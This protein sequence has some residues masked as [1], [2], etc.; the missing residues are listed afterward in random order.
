MF[1][2]IVYDV[3]RRALR[4][5][6]VAESETGVLGQPWDARS[7]PCWLTP[8][9]IDLQVN[10]L[11]GQPFN[12]ETLTTEAVHR[13]TRRLWQEG[14]A[15]YCPTLIT[16][17]VD[18]LEH[19][20]RTIARAAQDEPEGRAIVG[21]HLEG[22][23]I[24]PETGPRGAHPAEH[25]CDPDRGLFERLQEA[26]QGLIT[27]V[28]LAPERPGA[29]ALIE[30]L[31]T[32]GVIPAIGHTAAAP[33]LIHEAA[34]AGALLATHVGNAAHEHLHRH[35]NYIYAQLADE[36]LMASFIADGHHLPPGVLRIFVRAKSPE[37]SILVSDIM[38]W[39]GMEPG[40]YE[41]EHL[42]VEVTREGRAQI[43]GEPRLAGATTYLAACITNAA[44]WCALD[45]ETALAMA[46]QNP[47]KLLQISPVARQRLK[48]ATHTLLC[49][50][51]PA[52]VV[53]D[54]HFCWLDSDR[55]R[56]APTASSAAQSSSTG[57]DSPASQRAKT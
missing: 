25:V 27:L 41:W 4:R 34:A 52:G 5:L 8:G 26:A 32:A 51:R 40:V 17:R 11:L 18:R 31:R 38:H 21:I 47:R 37:R 57:S 30:W 50:G 2:E 14:V 9:W 24:S 39:A 36:R 33:E 42:K 3:E 45:L 44:A 16:D 35:R 56:R 54:G 6:S 46:A 1:D 19:A 10:G 53:F 23:F 20:L 49:D 29:L 22:P 13:I 28:T 15:Q 12:A 43:V 48:Y 7:A 55:L